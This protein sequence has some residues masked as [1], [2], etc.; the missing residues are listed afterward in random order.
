[1]ERGERKEKRRED[2]KKIEEREDE[3]RERTGVKSKLVD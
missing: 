2:G 3:K 1:M